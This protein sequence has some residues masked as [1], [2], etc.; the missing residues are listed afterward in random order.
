MQHHRAVAHVQRLAHAVGDHHGGQLILGDDAGRQ[1]QHE[2]SRARVQ[3]RSVLVQQQDARRLQGC[4]QQADRLALA[5]GQEADAVGQPVFQPQAQGGQAFAE[6]VLHRCL[7]RPTV[8][9]ARAAHLRQRHVLFDG[10]VFAGA[11]HRVLEH[12]GHAPGARPDGLARDVHA[13]DVDPARIHGQV[14]RHGV[15]KRGLAG[16]VGAD[17]SHELARRNIQRHAAQ[18]AGFDGRAGVESNFEIFS[19]QHFST[20]LCSRSTRA[21]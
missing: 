12:A 13:I 20:P 19:G 7:D 21:A 2:V 17:D 4:H 1:L 18:C 15:Q 10:Q 16:A 9:T 14:A 11:G 6:T 5:A 3:R 8:A